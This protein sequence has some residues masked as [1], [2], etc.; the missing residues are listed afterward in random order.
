MKAKRFF[1][2]PPCNPHRG[3]AAGLHHDL[4]GPSTPAFGLETLIHLNPRYVTVELSFD[5]R[6][7]SLS[8]LTCIHFLQLSSHSDIGITVTDFVMS[9]IS[10]RDKSGNTV[11]HAAASSK[12]AGSL[13]Y[14]LNLTRTKPL[15]SE[16][17]SDRNLEGKT[18]QDLIY[19]AVNKEV[20]RYFSRLG[21]DDGKIVEYNLSEGKTHLLVFRS[22][23]AYISNR[24]FRSFKYIG[25]SFDVEVELVSI[26]TSEKE[27]EDKVQS[28]LNC[29]AVSALIVLIVDYIPVDMKHLLKL[30]GDRTL[31]GKPKVLWTVT[32]WS[33]Y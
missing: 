19:S 24:T 14:L 3:V 21:V 8:N 20:M 5:F 26:S 6:S 28:T 30:M 11:L 10:L 1:G 4:C 22:P 27:I 16:L 2:V 33:S 23:S 31:S 9:M 18:P 15:H 32:I 13:Y 29:G 25:C 12:Y 17:W 7:G